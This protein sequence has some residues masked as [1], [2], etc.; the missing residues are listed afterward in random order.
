MMRVCRNDGEICFTATL[1]QISNEDLISKRGYMVGSH[2]RIHNILDMRDLLRQ[3]CRKVHLFLHF[4][5]QR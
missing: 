2:D 4:F 3:A 5:Q 1:S